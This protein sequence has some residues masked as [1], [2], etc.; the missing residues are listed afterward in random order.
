V[1]SVRSGGLVVAVLCTLKAS[2]RPRTPLG[3]KSCNE[4]KGDGAVASQYIVR[5]MSYNRYLN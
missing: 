1:N 3:L 2:F 4:S 5:S